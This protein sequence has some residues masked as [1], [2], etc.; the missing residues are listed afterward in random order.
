M[1]Y[2]NCWNNL[3]NDQAIADTSEIE[4]IFPPKARGIKQNEIVKMISKL[5]S[6]ET[7]GKSIKGCRI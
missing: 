5:E 6:S 2:L 7:C 4:S 3:N 1:P